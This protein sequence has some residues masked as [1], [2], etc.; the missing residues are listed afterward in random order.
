MKI[1]ISN[2]SLACHVVECNVLRCQL[3]SCGDN[4]RVAD[5]VRK[6]ECPLQ[7]LHSAEAAASHR[8]KLVDAQMISQAD[9]CLYPVFH[10]HNREIRTVTLSGLGVDTRR[11]GGSMTT[12]QIV[13]SD[14]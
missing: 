6:I 12:A 11:A 8:G 13:Y 7:R 1:R 4:E 5:P 2:D 3:G 9:L 14:H 10:C